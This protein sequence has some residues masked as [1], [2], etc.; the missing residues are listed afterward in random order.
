MMLATHEMKPMLLKTFSSNAWLLVSW[1][2][3]Y[4]VIVVA[5]NSDDCCLLISL[6]K[7]CYTLAVF[8]ACEPHQCLKWDPWTRAPVHS[9]H[10]QCLQS[11]LTARFHR[12]CSRVSKTSTVNTAHEHALW[13]RVVCWEKRNSCD[14]VINRAAYECGMS[15]ECVEMI[16]IEMIHIEV[17][18]IEVIH[19]EMIHI[20]MIH[21][22]MIHIEMIHIE[23][24]HIE[25]I[26][27]PCCAFIL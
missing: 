6:C 15:P 23:M 8:T 10:Y 24:I 1:F 14:S 13:T 19:I 2:V 9:P 11:M 3:M 7:A 5:V 4:D 22:E 21:I 26:H 25:V 27:A 17:I 12:S 16:H 18:H 20:E